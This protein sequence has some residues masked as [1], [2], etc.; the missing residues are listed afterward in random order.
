MLINIK[1]LLL[2]GLQFLFIFL[3]LSGTS[4]IHISLLAITFIFLSLVLI[5]WAIFAMQKSKLSILPEPAANAI[6]ITNGPYHYIRHPMYT[7]ILLCSTG[8]LIH[9]FSPI[10]L[11]IAIALTIVLVIKLK[12]EEKMLLQKFDAYDLY[13]RNTKCLLPFI[14]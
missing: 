7:A 10:R 6:L 9:Q 3:L 1:S 8:L 5:F 4:I 14:Y 11:A 2:A 13:M 12:W